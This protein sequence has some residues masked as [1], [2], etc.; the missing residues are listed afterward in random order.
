[1]KAFNKIFSAVTAAIILLFAVVNMILAADKTDGSRPYRVEISRLVREIE[2]N[3]SADISECAYVTNIC[4]LY[5]SPS[6]R[7]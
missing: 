5:T 6:P 1:M 2:T 4:L 3:G 7:D